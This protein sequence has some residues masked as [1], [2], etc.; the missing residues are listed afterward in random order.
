VSTLSPVVFVTITAFKSSAE[1]TFNKVGLPTS[2]SLDKLAEAW[3]RAHVSAYAIN[4]AVVVGLAVSVIVLSA[5]PAAFALVHLRFPLRRLAVIGIIGV[6][7]MPP[8]V[9]M[10]PIFRTV[11]QLG[12][13]NSYVGLAL[14]YATLNLPFSIYLMTAFMR[15]VPIE[16][17]EAA[18]IDGASVGRRLWSIVIPLVR[19]GILALATLN[20]V[21][22][23]NELLFALLVL[24]DE[25]MR[26]LMVGVA[27]LRGQHTS[28]IP[29][30]S[31]GLLISMIPPIVV[32]LALQ[33]SLSRGLTVGAVR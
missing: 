11:H 33:R 26:T 20:L 18:A 21:W 23:W 27:L 9:L 31:A 19:P 5:L 24:Q 7:M 14:V 1:Y 8:S 28:D 2:W 17:L 3:D 32:F 16:V 13:L 30:I 15:S 10:I 4:S 29:L 25:P 12:L 6:M 22:L